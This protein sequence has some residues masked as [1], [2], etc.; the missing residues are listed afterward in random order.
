M[1]LNNPVAHYNMGSALKARGRWAEALVHFRKALALNPDSGAHNNIGVILAE[2]EQGDLAVAHWQ[3]A[4]A[5]APDDPEAFANYGPN[6]CSA[7][8]VR[9]GHGLSC[10]SPGH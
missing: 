7:R 9:S 4:M 10:Q 2:Q 3:Q 1:T 6:A 8:A 5:L